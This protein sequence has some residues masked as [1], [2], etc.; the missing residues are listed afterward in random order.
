MQNYLLCLI[1]VAFMST[2]QLIFR[3]GMRGKSLASLED[4]VRAMF[5][6]IIILG[7]LIYAFSTLLWCYILS[8]VPLSFAYPIQAL[9]FP[10]VLIL[11]TVFLGEPSSVIKWLGV[12]CIVFGTIIATKFG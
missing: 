8:R 11:S 7:I 3:F 2:G 6:P 12:G 10:A 4:I 5:S 1:N 9:A